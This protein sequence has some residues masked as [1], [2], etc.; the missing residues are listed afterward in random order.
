[1]KFSSYERKI[2]PEPKS[3]PEQK[4]EFDRA[5]HFVVLLPVWTR[6]GISGCSM[7]LWIR[8]DSLKNNQITFASKFGHEK[9]IHSSSWSNN[10]NFLSFLSKFYSIPKLGLEFLYV[11][12]CFKSEMIPF[13]LFNRIIQIF[14]FFTLA[15]LGDWGLHKSEIIS[16]KIVSCKNFSEI[17]IHFYCGGRILSSALLVNSCSATD[18]QDEPYTVR[19]GCTVVNV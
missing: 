10:W 4:S 13:K 8:N 6:L 2:E 12:G 18:T 9:K 3:E 15:Y 19:L 5:T 7:A 16:F 1:M 14:K 17:G 11:R